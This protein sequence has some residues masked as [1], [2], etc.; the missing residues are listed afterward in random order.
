MIR[1]IWV[2]LCKGRLSPKL[3]VV[4][5]QHDLGCLL[6][7]PK[8][9]ST[10]QHCIRTMIATLHS[11]RDV[12][13]NYKIVL[14]AIGQIIVPTIS[15]RACC[16]HFQRNSCYGEIICMFASQHALLCLYS[17]SSPFVYQSACTVFCSCMIFND[18]RAG[19]MTLPS[20]S[21]G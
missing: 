17:A 18:P 21:L 6:C 2:Y 12:S 14:N 5:F 16:T 8:N 11:N 7:S 3:A 10:K 19:V 4:K 9:C 13:A 1:K 20:T 15:S